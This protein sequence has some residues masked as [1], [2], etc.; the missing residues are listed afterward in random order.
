MTPY[1][2]IVVFEQYYAPTH[3]YIINMTVNKSIKQKMWLRMIGLI[4]TWDIIYNVY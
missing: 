2:K 4:E 3:L 1:R